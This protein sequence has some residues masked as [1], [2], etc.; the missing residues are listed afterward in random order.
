MA[1]EHLI[2]FNKNDATA[3]K[4][5]SGNARHAETVTDLTIGSGEN[6][7][8]AGDFDGSTTEVDFGNILDLGGSADDLTVFCKFKYDTNAGTKY[9]CDKDNHFRLSIVS[10]AGSPNVKFEVYIGA[11]WKTVTGATGLTAATWYEVAGWY[12]GTDLKVYVNGS[13]DATT[14]QAGNVDASSSDFFIGSSGAADFID[15]QIETLAIYSDSLSTDAITALSNVPEGLKMEFSAVHNLETG[16]L[17]SDDM[18]GLTKKAMCVWKE[19]TTVVYVW[20]ISAAKF[21]IGEA[22]VQCGHIWDTAR[23]NVCLF[24]NNSRDPE[25]VIRDGIAQFAD[26]TDGSTIRQKFTKDGTITHWAE[27]DNVLINQVFI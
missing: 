15:A 19:S 4:D 18:I 24:N 16:D 20:P 27:H 12:D 2:T 9:L 10:G 17:V 5:F 25:M 26:L 3:V 13:E 8:K 7:G 6:V 23:Q 14:A 22:P 1:L 11:A 21:F